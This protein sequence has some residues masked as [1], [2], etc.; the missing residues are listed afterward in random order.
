MADDTWVERDYV[1]LEYIVRRV[2]ADPGRG[3]QLRAIVDDTGISEDDVRRAMTALASARPPYFRD[4]VEIEELP[5]P[6][7]V[8]GVTERALR[9]VGQ[10]PSPEALVDQLI[11]AL[12]T[13]AERE[14]DPE[15]KSK[16]RQASETLGSVALQ[17]A[18]GWASGA[19]P[20]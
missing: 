1:V 17:V 6:I 7:Q 8:D 5:F 11:A 14:V 9:T 15:K 3:V 4:V 12:V 20:H 16:L 10:W 2:E 13:A 18:I 19:L